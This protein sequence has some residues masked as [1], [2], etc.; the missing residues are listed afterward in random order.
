MLTKKNKS[1]GIYG[2]SNFKRIVNSIETRFILEH[3]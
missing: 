1:G 3:V 2:K